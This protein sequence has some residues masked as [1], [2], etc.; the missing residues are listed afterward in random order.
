MGCHISGGNFHSLGCVSFQQKHHQNVCAWLNRQGPILCYSLLMFFGDHFVWPLYCDNSTDKGTDESMRL[1]WSMLNKGFI[2]GMQA[3]IILRLT[4]VLCFRQLEVLQR[5]SRMTHCPQTVA[6]TLNPN[7]FSRQL[8]RA[9]SGKCNAQDLS[10]LR[11]YS[12]RLASS[13]ALVMQTLVAPWLSLGLFEGRH[14]LTQ[15][16]WRRLNRLLFSGSS[17]SAHFSKAQTA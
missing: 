1:N 15:D 14:Y 4:E 10:A 8:V 7:T 12:F 6:S 17:W 9:T 2:N 3:V 16:E 13:S 11:K 5:F